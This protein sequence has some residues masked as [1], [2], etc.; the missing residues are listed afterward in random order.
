ME[1]TNLASNFKTLE[2]LKSNLRD[3]RRNPAPSQG[4]GYKQAEDAM[5]RLFGV[6]THR[7]EIDCLNQLH[8]AKPASEK[9]Q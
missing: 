3:A 9:I 2:G 8:D 7:F 6:Y 5:L 4:P 1:K